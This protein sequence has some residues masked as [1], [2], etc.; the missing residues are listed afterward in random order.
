MKS[1]WALKRNGAE[2]VDAE[3][4]AADERK[5]TGSSIQKKIRGGTWME[6]SRL[7]VGR[8]NCRN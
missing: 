3:G 7:V 6:K 2:E 4:E 5:E 1:S 8:R